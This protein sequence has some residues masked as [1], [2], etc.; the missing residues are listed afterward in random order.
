M[1]TL[2]ERFQF[3]NKNSKLFTDVTINLTHT[4]RQI[5]D[6]R[7]NYGKT[8][9]WF[10]PLNSGKDSIAGVIGLSFKEIK[11][12]RKSKEW[13]AAVNMWVNQASQE[14]MSFRQELAKYH[15]FC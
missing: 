13:I 6:M 11:N 10:A 1:K 2:D 4:A 5:I 7:I 8:K 12:L 3:T 15:L 14:D 9:L